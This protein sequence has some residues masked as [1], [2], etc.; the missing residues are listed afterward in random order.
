MK[1][2]ALIFL[3]VPAILGC[4]GMKQTYT[5]YHVQTGRQVTMRK[6]SPR[7]EEVVDL[8]TNRFRMITARTNGF[9]L[10]HVRFDGVTDR[11]VELPFLSQYIAR[12]YGLCTELYAISNDETRIAFF[13]L[14]TA[15]LKLVDVQAGTE[16]VLVREVTTNVPAVAW[17]QWR[18]ADELLFAIS[19]WCGD[20]ARVT[21]VDVRSG[22]ISDLAAGPGLWHIYG[23]S[24]SRNGKFLGCAA[25]S[26]RSDTNA[27]YVH[28][29]DSR[30]EVDRLVSREHILGKPLWGDGLDFVYLDG[31]DLMQ[32]SLDRKHTAPVRSFSK[33]QSVY[34]RGFERGL[35]FYKVSPRSNIRR[36]SLVAFDIR[37]HTEREIPAPLEGHVYVAP[38]GEMILSGW[39]Y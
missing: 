28:D 5:L 19:G 33:E 16:S 11:T 10:K 4:G 35:V 13:D 36:S 26:R 32:Y 27:I 31:D 30:T 9:E 6:Q 3:I 12:W 15:E 7:P 24:L 22:S 29:I 20:Q 38:G 23:L 8:W 17:L 21:L 25:S 34:L 39:G 18:S 2:A 1:N 14:N 37:R